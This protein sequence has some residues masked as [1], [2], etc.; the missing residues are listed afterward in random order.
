MQRQDIGRLHRLRHKIF[1]P[2]QDVD[3]HNLSIRLLCGRPAGHR[4]MAF[5]LAP[6]QIGHWPQLTGVPAAY[7]GG[8]STLLNI[9][10][11]PANRGPRVA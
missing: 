3:G 5:E 1:Q 2:R 10:S 4:D 11:I 9:P 6:G 8:S 7:D